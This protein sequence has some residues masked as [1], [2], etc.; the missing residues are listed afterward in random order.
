MKY[1]LDFDDTTFDAKKLKRILSECGIAED[2]VSETTFDEIKNLKPDFDLK[3]LIFAD[4]LRFLQAHRDDC[5]IVTTYLSRDSQKNTDREARK[6]YQIE[7]IA[8][9][10]ITKLLGVEHVHFTAESKKGVLAGLKQKY[11]A[12][13]E[14]CVYIDDSETYIREAEELGIRTFLMKREKVIGP[15]EFMPSIEGETGV[16]SFDELE[17]K[18]P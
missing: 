3:T 5:E 13:G 7:K 12:L 2:S 16:S 1:I 9:C 4:A 8:L 6:R 11:D 14:D 10:G 15:F 18:L 17:D